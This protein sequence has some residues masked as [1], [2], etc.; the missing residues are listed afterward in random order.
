M[1]T[2][3][4]YFVNSIK[5]SDDGFFLD[6]LLL[7]FSLILCYSFFLFLYSF[8]GSIRLF[9]EYRFLLYTLKSHSYHGHQC[10]S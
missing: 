3:L 10:I 5:T 4:S 6:L 2:Y 8:N 1:F 7:H 9:W